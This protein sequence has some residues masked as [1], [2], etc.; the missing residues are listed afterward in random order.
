[1][2]KA[3]LLFCIP[4]LLVSGR[5][6]SQTNSK[7]TLADA[8]N[9]IIGFNHIGIVV[10]DLE[11]MVAFYQGT[12]EFEIIKRELITGSAAAD[13]LYNEK[14]ISYETVTFK[15]PNMLL[16]LTQFA[17]PLDEEIQ[18]M[19]P[20]G[21]GMTHTCYQSPSW[22]S[23]YQKFK[24]QNAEILSKG[25]APVDLGGYGVTYAYAYDPEGNMIE[26]E[27]LDKVVLDNDGYDANWQDQ[28]SMWMTQ[29]ALISPDLI[30]LSNYYEMVL[31]FPPRRKATLAN[32]AKLDDIVGMDSIALHAAWFGMDGEGKMMELMQYVHPKTVVSQGK[33]HLKSL[34][35]SFSFEVESIQ[36]EYKRLKGLNVEFISEPQILGE[37][38]MVFAH[39]LDGNIFQLRQAISNDS[40]YSLNNFYD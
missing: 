3:F 24:S 26:M 11:E 32:M 1:M 27:Q 9:T 17:N 31:E 40:S 35:Y 7:P 33:K 37:F 5:L 38:W 4:L 14:N 13:K 39:D 6:L 18:K 36:Q 12:T 2:N 21:P 23:G 16:E 19:P 34:G 15:A 25:D 29:V 10:Q 22:K 20:E 30:E 8:P 28:N